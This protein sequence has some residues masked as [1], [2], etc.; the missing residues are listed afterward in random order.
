MQ[1]RSHSLET[2]TSKSHPTTQVYLGA[3]EIVRASILEA[4]SMMLQSTEHHI[5]A[6][7]GLKKS[8]ILEIMSVM[9]I[10]IDWATGLWT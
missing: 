4:A 10:L 9:A 1:Q 7:D 8:P 5:W 2:T 6:Q 3:C